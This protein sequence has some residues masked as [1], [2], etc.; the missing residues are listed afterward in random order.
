MSALARPRGATPG[1]APVHESWNEPGGR[2]RWPA[3]LALAL[4]IEAALLGVLAWLGS[5]R[6]PPPPPPVEITLSQPRPVPRPVTPKPPPPK[7]HPKPQPKPRPH[8]VHPHPKPL[9]RP[10]PPPPQPRALISPPSPQPAAKPAMPVVPPAPAPVPPMPH[11]DLAATR[12]SFE[13]AL[14]E[15]VQAAV[16]FPEAARLMHAGGRVLVGFDFLD[17]KVSQVRVVQSS[18]VDMLDAAAM[19]AV[20]EAPYPPTP[21]ALASQPMRFRIWV[22]FH[23]ESR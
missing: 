17:G 7:P 14:R 11:P 20:R 4:L 19:A 16:R 5:H 21:A 9:P 6:A 18:G 2:G 10:L 12:L 1:A 23:L 8:P 13:A 15:A 22:R 3:A